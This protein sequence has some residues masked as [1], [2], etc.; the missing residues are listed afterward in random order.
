MND[1]VISNRSTPAPIVGFYESRLTDCLE[2]TKRYVAERDLAL[3]ERDQ[4]IAKRDQALLDHYCSHAKTCRANT[5]YDELR[6]S[7][8]IM[9]LSLLAVIAVLA[10]ALMLA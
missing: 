8:V 2:L 10:I 5:R 4:A 3:V 1:N 6:K 9:C 7:S